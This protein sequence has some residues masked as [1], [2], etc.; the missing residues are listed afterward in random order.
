MIM[1]KNEIIK[2]DVVTPFSDFKKSK[3]I[4]LFLQIRLVDLQPW[5]V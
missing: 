4:G 1:L 2:S 3:N 5:F